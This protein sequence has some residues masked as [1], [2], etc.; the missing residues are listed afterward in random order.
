MNPQPP[1][2]RVLV[3]S[4]RLLTFLFWFAAA[5]GVAALVV[6]A[7]VSLAPGGVTVSSRLD[8]RVPR[9][10]ALQAARIGALGS[11]LTVVLLLPALRVLRRVVESAIAGD[12]FVP[13]NG[14]RL[15]QLA[16]LILG[17]DI[18]THG[19]ALW[20]VRALRIEGTP[21]NLPF[22]FTGLLMVAMALVLAHIFEHGTRLRADVQGTV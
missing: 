1:A 2:P 22:S 5:G 20:V 12:P 8:P 18:V 14:R 21:L 11:A 9:E 10:A 16:G 4:R 15:R 17:V 6:L 7:A 19:M 13:D 3:L